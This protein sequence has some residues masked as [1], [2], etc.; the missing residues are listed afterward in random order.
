MT[1]INVP[2]GAFSLMAVI[3]GDGDLETALFAESGKQVG[4]VHSFTIFTSDPYLSPL[5]TLQ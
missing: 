3:I 5:Q 2:K 1:K 4:S